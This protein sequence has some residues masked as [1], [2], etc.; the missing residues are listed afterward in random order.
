MTALEGRQDDRYCDEVSIKAKEMGSHLNCVALASLC[1]LTKKYLLSKVVCSLPYAIRFV[2]TKQ[3]Y[4]RSNT[5]EAL[6]VH[7]VE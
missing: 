6:S 4:D 3:V 1:Q 7:A 5:G 2:A